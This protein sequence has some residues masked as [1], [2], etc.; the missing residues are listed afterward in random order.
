M[1]PAWFD[2]RSYVHFRRRTAKRAT[3]LSER[4]PTSGRAPKLAGGGAANPPEERLRIS[5]LGQRGR[6]LVRCVNV[7]YKTIAVGRTM[8]RSYRRVSLVG[9]SRSH[10]SC[11]YRVPEIDLH[12]I[13]V[14][15]ER[16]VEV[17]QPRVPIFEEKRPVDDPSD[18]DAN[19]SARP[20]SKNR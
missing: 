15:P 20:G 6:F 10:A 1:A 3:A 17:R 4:S 8:L 13:V 7:S 12:R 16:S 14:D 5:A 2:I 9:R 11:I 19:G 18:E